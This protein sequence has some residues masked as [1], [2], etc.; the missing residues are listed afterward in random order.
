MSILTIASATA[1]LVLYCIVFVLWVKTMKLS[2]SRMD[3][4]DIC[5]WD[6]PLHDHHDGC[7]ACYIADKY[8]Y[9]T[10]EDI[11]KGMKE[12]IQQKKLIDDDVDIP[13]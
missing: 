12:L 1:F 13:Y 5:P 2:E 8:G 9:K 6:E 11:S 7:P 10:S 3:S 4:K